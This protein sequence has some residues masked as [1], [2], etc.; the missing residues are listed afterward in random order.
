MQKTEILGAEPA[1]AR[2]ANN[3]IPRKDAENFYV[4]AASFFSSSGWREN[5]A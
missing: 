4:P 5:L 2:R 3:E 1:A